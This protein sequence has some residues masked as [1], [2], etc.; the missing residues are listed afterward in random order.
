MLHC[1][2][3]LLLKLSK[4]GSSKCSSAYCSCSG[5]LSCNHPI[6][7]AFCHLGKHR[8][9][10]LQIFTYFQFEF[11]FNSTI[12]QFCYKT[13]SLENSTDCCSLPPTIVHSQSYIFPRTLTVIAFPN[14]S[15]T[16]SCK[17]S[18]NFSN[19]RPLWFCNGE[20]FPASFPTSNATDK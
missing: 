12:L 20:A 2:N 11:D 19:F 5:I 4:R 10:I 7:A 16:R 18:L 3:M 14:G 13:I 8:I 6:S 1:K 15:A 9:L 17:N